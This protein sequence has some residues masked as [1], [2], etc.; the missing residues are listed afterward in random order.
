MP[1]DIALRHRA[2]QRVGDRVQPDIG[3]R[4]AGQRPIMRDVD[5]AECDA[6]TRPERMNVE[7]LA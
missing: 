6:G 4:M 1:T 2:E 3:V 5:T 7:A